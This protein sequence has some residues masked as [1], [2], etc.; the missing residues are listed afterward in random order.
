MFILTAVECKRCI[1][2]FRLCIV[3]VVGHNNLCEVTHH[4][5]HEACSNPGLPIL[6][7]CGFKNP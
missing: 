6:I 4:T 2:W 1:Y 5:L 3:M 7:C